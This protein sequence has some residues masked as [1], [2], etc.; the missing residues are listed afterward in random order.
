[1]RHSCPLRVC[2]R[3]RDINTKHPAPTP[4]ERPKRE[5]SCAVYVYVAFPIAVTTFFLRSLSSS[6]PLPC[7]FRPYSSPR[8]CALSRGN[9]AIW[10]FHRGDGGGWIRCKGA[11]GHL[12]LFFS[13]GTG[14]GFSGRGK[15]AAGQLNRGEGV[16]GSA[17]GA[18]RLG[19]RASRWWWRGG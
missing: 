11:T 16:G 12:R 9:E 7:L 15:W 5:A 13:G 14:M 17:G 18:G 2:G 10:Q 19:K 6:S 8:P 4:I 3:A 1:M